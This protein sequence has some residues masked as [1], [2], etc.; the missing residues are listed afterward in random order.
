MPTKSR[1]QHNYMEM[2]AHDPKAA[3]RTGVS[4]S[5]A[6]EFV[7]ADKGRDLKKLAK[8]VKGGKRG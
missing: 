2:I 7:E 1:A 3:K 6:K 4:Q 5:V 8:H